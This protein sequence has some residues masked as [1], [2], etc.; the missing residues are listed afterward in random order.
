MS[1]GSI[2]NLNCT[3]C[4]W[5]LMP[6]YERKLI[7]RC[8]EMTCCSLSDRHKTIYQQSLPAKCIFVSKLESFPFQNPLIHLQT[9]FLVCIMAGDNGRDRFSWRE[10]TRKK[11]RLVILPYR[12]LFLSFVIFGRG[13]QWP[14]WWSEMQAVPPRLRSR[15]Q[16]QA[17]PDHRAVLLPYQRRTWRWWG[18]RSTS[19]ASSSVALRGKRSRS[20][21]AEKQRLG[22]SNVEPLIF[23]SKSVQCA[24]IYL[25]DMHR[26][27]FNMFILFH[28]FLITR[29]YYSV[30]CVTVMC[31]CNSCLLHDRITVLFFRC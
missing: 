10:A 24:M 15:S 3:D 5:W 13:F 22:G 29:L 4:T 27:H 1:N 16:A 8:R 11:E 17:P 6:A 14:D 26:I 12:W 9:R 28:V 21:P 7:N 18:A 20:W 23:N 19:S 31:V 30:H 25:L 2:S